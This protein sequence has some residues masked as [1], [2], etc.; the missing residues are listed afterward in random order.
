M[1][2]LSAT[3]ALLL[4][5]CPAP[6]NRPQSPLPPPVAGAGCPAASDVYA[7][8]YLTPE[9]PTSDAPGHTG[10]VLP[11]HD[12]KVDSVAGQPE[13]AAIDAAAAGDAGVPPAPTSVWLLTPGQPPCKA[14]VGTYYSAAIDGPA[15]NIT[16]GVALDGC[17]AS[18]AD[19]QQSARA[20]AV[21]AEQ[22]PTE[23][24]IVA[25]QP[26]AF[27]LGETDAQKAWQRPTKETAIPPAL[28]AA[29]P[30]H[31]CRAPGCETLWAF[32]QV[33]VAGRAV[34]WGGT[35]NWLTIPPG[36]TPASQCDW[37]A[38]TFAGFFVPGPDGQAVRVTEG[39]D[40]PLLLSAVLADRSGA[41]VLLAEGPGEYS[42]YDLVVG[43]ARLGR[44]LVWLRMPAEDYESDDHIGPTCEPAP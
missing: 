41:R 14:T 44:H 7:A 17:A 40:H 4:A 5:G 3:F 20:I 37:K 34:A 8:S 10:W 30:A 6:G 23:C 33:E 11:L 1:M 16:Y 35:V 26:I 9:E 39:Q 24:Q 27:R 32:V 31:D 19:Q 28:A 38:E 22:A 43:A 21:A 36:A 29:I 2:R 15:P 12:R 18:P 42:T 25:P 13:Y